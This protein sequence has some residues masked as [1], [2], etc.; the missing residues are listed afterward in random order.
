MLRKIIHT[1][2]GLLAAA[3]CIT[4]VSFVAIWNGWIGYMPDIDDLQNPISRSATQVISSDGKL[5][6]TWSYNKENRVLVNYNDISR[7]VV[8]ALVATEDARFYDHSGIDFIASAE[9]S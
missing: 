8:E 5:L 3:V 7:H 2:W 4:V 6:G 1:L 9:P